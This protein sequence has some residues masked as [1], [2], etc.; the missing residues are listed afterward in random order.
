LFHILF[1][2]RQ[3]DRQTDRHVG[4]ITKVGKT[5]RKPSTSRQE[6]VQTQAGVFACRYIIFNVQA[7]SNQIIFLLASHTQNRGRVNATRFI[8]LRLVQIRV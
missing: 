3:T 1:V 6:E 2:D 5:L 4:L 8:R 7:C